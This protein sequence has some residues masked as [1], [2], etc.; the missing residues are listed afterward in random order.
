MKRKTPQPAP[1]TVYLGKDR[2]EDRIQSLDALAA[3]YADENL[4]KLVQ[5]IADGELKIVDAR[6]SE[7]AA[8]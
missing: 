5:L 3:K 7:R 8:S 4:S 6:R 1:I 2:R